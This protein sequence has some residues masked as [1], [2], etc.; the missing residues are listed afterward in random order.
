MKNSQP[1]NV[2]K[3]YWLTLS[4]IFVAM[5]SVYIIADG[6]WLVAGLAVLLL[7]L[8]IVTARYGQ[9]SKKAREYGRHFSPVLSLVLAAFIGAGFLARGTEA[10]PY[11]TPLLG[12]LG[13]V[14]MYMIMKK[15]N[16]YHAPDPA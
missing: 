11:L 5:L 7:S 14:V 1:D 10:A 3:N 12:I 13:G 15:H 2:A 9:F 6:W 8:A 16:M 4:G